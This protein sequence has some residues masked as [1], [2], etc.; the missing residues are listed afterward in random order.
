MYAQWIPKVY[1]F[2]CVEHTHTLEWLMWKSIHLQRHVIVF[3]FLLI[4]GE[5]FRSEFLKPVPGKSLF[6]RLS[7]EEGVA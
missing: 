1:I 7:C 5:K 2:H 3:Q 6:C 4:F